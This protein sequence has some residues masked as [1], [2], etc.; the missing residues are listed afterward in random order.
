MPTM[1][2]LMS[3]EICAN[4]IHVLVESLEYADTR[5]SH[6]LPYIDSLISSNERNTESENMNIHDMYHRSEQIDVDVDHTRRWLSSM[7]VPRWIW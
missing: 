6:A 3:I 2:Y 4:N 7:S 5:A 1:L